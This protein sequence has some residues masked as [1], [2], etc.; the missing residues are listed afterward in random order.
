MERPECELRQLY[1]FAV[2]AE[3]L[4]FGRAAVRLGISQPP[5]SQQ[6][7]RLED[8]VGHRLLARGTRSVRLTEA[9]ASLLTLAH[10]LLDEASAGLARARQAGNGEA[11]TLNLGFTA[12]TAL[13]MLPKILQRLRA[14]LPEIHVSLFELLP[15]ALFAALESERI[16]VALAREMIDVDRFEVAALH[17]EP[18]V[19]VLPA[20]HREAGGTGRMDL[21]RLRDDGFILFPRD[22]RSRNFDMLVDMC[23]AAGFTP[24]PTQEAPGWQTAVSFVGAG[25]GVTILPACVRAFALPGVA[26]RDLDITATSTIL[27]LRRRDDQRRLVESF[28]NSARAAIAAP[29]P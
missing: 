23:R 28:W 11:G 26:F 9:G 17:A 10:R 2:V 27:L 25:L 12:T 1:V 3:E 4:H 13:S 24:R 15:D 16:D 5:L 22:D 29:A 18:Y 19:A 20:G 6:I 14:A 7:K 21:A 8:L